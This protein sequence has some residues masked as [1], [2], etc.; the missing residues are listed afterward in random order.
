MLLVDTGPDPIPPAVSVSRFA[1]AVAAVVGAW[2]VAA[3]RWADVG[4]VS[5]WQSASAASRG[6]LLSL[7]W[8]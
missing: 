8:P 7:R 2:K 3:S 5:P 6:R 1:D 4:E